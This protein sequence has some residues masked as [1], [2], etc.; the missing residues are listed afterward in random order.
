MNKDNISKQIKIID[1]VTLNLSKPDSTQPTWIGQDEILKQIHA[2]W[3]VISDKDHPLSPR[4][5]GMPGTGKTTLAMVAAQQRK[6]P[7]YIFQ[8]TSDTRPED[9]LITPV[10]SEKGTISYHASPLVCA[11]ITGGIC[12]LDEGNRMNEKSWASLAPL[13]DHRRYVESIIAGIQIH[14]H[15]EFRACV[16]M[17]NDESTFE[18]PDYILS[19]LQP[20]LHMSMPS[21]EDEI[22]ILRYH[23]PFSEEELLKMTVEFLQKSHQ[24]DLEFSP[25]DGIH[26]LQYALKRLSQEKD[27]PLSKDDVWNES[28]SKVL[29]EDAMD[30]DSL[31]AK[32]S[33]SLQNE[34]FPMGL[35]DFF[36]NEDNPLHPDSDK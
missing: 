27:H 3:L 33:R 7:L 10:L 24:L 18:I 1:G 36:F 6:Q 23:L 32:N 25:R 22:E 15:K 28:I 8:C 19:R 30:L 20:T 31:A 4:I 13:L 35:G 9:L 14:A 26:I 29:G 21:Y 34:N 5:T 11:M 12:I 2:C 17:N 16:T